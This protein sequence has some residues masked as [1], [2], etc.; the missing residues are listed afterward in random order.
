MIETLRTLTTL[1]IAA[2]VVQGLVL[3]VIAWRRRSAKPELRW[4]ALLMF[5][6]AMLSALDYVEDASIAA[7]RISIGLLWVLLLPAPALWCYVRAILGLPPSTRWQTWH[8]FVPAAAMVIPSIVVA[9]TAS[10]SSPSSWI[11]VWI[12]ALTIPTAVGGACYLGACLYWIDRHRKAL[13]LVLANVEAQELKWLQILLLLAIAIWTTWLAGLWFEHEAVRLL[14][15]MAQPI[16]MLIIGIKAIEQPQILGYQWLAAQV[17]TASEPSHPGIRPSYA[18]SGLDEARSLQLV[19]R[20]DVLMR[21]EK[22]YLEEDLS[23]P[24][25]AERLSIPP[26]WL[27]QLLNQRLQTTFHDYIAEFRVRDV[28]RCLRDPAFANQS[29]LAIATDA[30]FRSKSAFNEAFRRIAGTTPSRYRQQLASNAQ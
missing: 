25:L 27:S 23:L 4:F 19:S 20:L 28:M 26:Q 30:G 17:E 10:M 3:A 18:K 5:A 11:G 2:A 13:R 29:I 16:C 14:A 6:L 1:L 7:V 9:L 8:H 24:K 15:G 12:T 22:P 21:T